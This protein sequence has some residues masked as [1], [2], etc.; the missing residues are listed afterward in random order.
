MTRCRNIPYAELGIRGIFCS[1]GLCR[2]TAPVTRHYR[3]LQKITQCPQRTMIWIADD[4]MIEH[5]D[6]QELARPDEV[7]SYFDVGLGRRWFTTRMVVHHHD[8]SGC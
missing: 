3:G 2:G 1:V 6:L 7:A 5:F 8:S 4:H